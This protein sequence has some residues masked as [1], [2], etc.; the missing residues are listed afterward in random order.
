MVLN[1]Y[2]YESVCGKNNLKTSISDRLKNLK[3]GRMFDH[4]K[5]KVFHRGEF[6]PFDQAT[7]SIANTG[8]LYGLGVFTGMR[9][10][11]NPSNHKLYI[12]RV[13]DH[14]ERMRYSC[15]LMR[16][17]N[18]LKSYSLAQFSEILRELLIVNKIDQDAYF[19]VTNFSDETKIGPSLKGYHDSLSI[20]PYPLGDYVSTSGLKCTVAS[21]QR[22]HDNSIPARAKVNGIYVN[23]ALAKTEALMSGFD[24]AIFLDARGNVVEG[25]AENIFIVRDGVLVTPPVNDHILEGITR[26]TIIEIAKD[27]G[28]SCVERSISRSELYKADE[29]FLTGTGAKIAPVVEID[30]YQVSG[31]QV[32]PISRLLQDS[33]LSAARGELPEYRRWVEEVDIAGE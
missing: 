15:K 7:V 22:V 6:V 29:I 27:K 18:F 20:Y 24:E 4:K 11:R 21:W 31:A 25:S 13:S 33:Y 19:R 32:G 1:T 12:F 23:T 2:C 30:N 8:F 5:C 16:F 26:Q 14:Y 9:A 28:I 17:E 10:F 3:R